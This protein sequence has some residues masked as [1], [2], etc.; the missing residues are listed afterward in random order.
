MTSAINHLKNKFQD[1]SLDIVLPVY[2]LNLVLQ[3]GHFFPNLQEINIWDEATYVH[4][5]VKLLTQGSLPRL[6]GSPLSSVFY[7]LTTLPVQHSKDF[8]LLSDA[9]GRIILF[10]FI[11]FSA[12]F[13]ACALKPYANPWVMLVLVFIVPVAATMFLFPSDI[14]FAGFSGLAFWQ[15]LAFYHHK[16]RKHLWWASVLMGLAALARAEGLILILVMLV[17]TMVIILPD[18]NWYKYILAVTLPF[19]VLVGGYVLGYGLATG[20]YNTGLAER[21]YNNFESGHEGIYSQT[22]VFIPTIS[23]RLESREAFGTPEMNDY[24]VFKAILRNPRVYWLRL[25]RMPFVLHYLAVKAYGNKFILIFIWLAIRGAVALIQQKHYPLLLMGVLWFLPWGAGVLNTFFREGY[26][27]TPYFVIFAFSAI[28]LSAVIKN[29][30]KKAERIGIIAAGSVVLIVA[31]LLKNTSMFYRSALFLFGLGI[32]YLIWRKQ[33]GESNWRRQAWWI[34]LAMGLIIRG[35][36]ISPELPSYGRTD[37]ERSVYTL[38]EILPTESEVL[39]G[40]PANVWAARMT[41]YGINSYD[42]P[43]FSDAEAFLDWI[44]KQGIDAVYVDKYFPQ[45]YLNFI[46]SF[47]DSALQEVYTTPERDIIIY[48]VSQGEP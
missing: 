13:I 20:D 24:S 44:Q 4:N 9:I 37:M 15:M 12:Y 26:F 21:T 8:F 36:Y 16:Q 33:E 23:A 28:G 32:I 7:A 17:V 29:F 11:F 39:A 43:E 6:I 47:A 3:F 1:L 34:L 30:D 19:V 27:M 31:V 35:S 22:G 48:L 40:A 25:R 2:I 10:S 45:V 46:S 5:G 14:L 41:Y 38:Q 42:I 18:R